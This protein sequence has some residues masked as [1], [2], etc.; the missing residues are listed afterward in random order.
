M[1]LILVNILFVCSF[2]RSLSEGEVKGSA[3]DIRVDHSLYWRLCY[4]GQSSGFVC[5][6]CVLGG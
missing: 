2:L 5:V 3:V 1:L 4:C 6:V